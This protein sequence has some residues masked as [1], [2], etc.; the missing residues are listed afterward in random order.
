MMR[1]FTKF[2]PGMIFG[3]LLFAGGVAVALQGLDLQTT[4]TMISTTT[5]NSILVAK[6]GQ[7]AL[8][9]MTPG[10]N[11]QLPVG[12]TG[13]PPVFQTLSGDVGSVTSGGV[14]TLSKTGFFVVGKMA[15]VNFNATGNTDIGQLG[16]SLNGCRAWQPLQFYIDNPQQTF[17]TA[18]FQFWTAAGGSGTSLSAL[19]TSAITTTSDGTAGNSQQIAATPGVTQTFSAANF[20]SVFLHLG[21]AQGATASADVDIIVRCLP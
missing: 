14:V 4:N 8:G 18:T 19:T 15:G 9:Y 6:G 7:Q 10:T 2:I 5:A 17:S 21:T 11:G 20:P 3:A 12:S 1:V 16:L 13:N